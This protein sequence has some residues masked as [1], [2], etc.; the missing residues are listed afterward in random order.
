MKKQWLLA[1]LCLSSIGFGTQD[2]ELF[3]AVIQGDTGVVKSLLNAGADV[4]AR[5]EA[6][7]T[8]LMHAAIQ[9]EQGMVRILIAQGADIDAEDEND[10]TALDHAKVKH[11]SGSYIVKLLR[12]LS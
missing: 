10:L 8:P 1:L 3:L 5:D 7:M 9:G 11:G 6:E 12:H 4:N 2:E